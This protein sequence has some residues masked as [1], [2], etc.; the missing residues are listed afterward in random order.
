[1][2]ASHAESFFTGIDAGIAQAGLDVTM[3][4]VD[5]GSHGGDVRCADFPSAGVCAWVADE[6]FGFL[7]LAPPTGGD[8][9]QAAQDVRDA[10]E[11]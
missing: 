9:E 2:T 3:T 8:L 7:S 5:P 10:I 1:M 4:A 11:H 6:T